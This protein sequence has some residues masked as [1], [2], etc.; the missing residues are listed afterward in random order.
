MSC[1][2]CCSA[3]VAEFIAEMMIHF[4]GVKH[5]TNPGLLLFPEVSI[6][7]DCGFSWFTLPETELASLV[8]AAPTTNGK[9]LADRLPDLRACYWG[10]KRSCSTDRNSWERGDP[11]PLCCGG[12]WGGEWRGSERLCLR[13][14]VLRSFR[15]DRNTEKGRDD[16]IARSQHFSRDLLQGLKMQ[17]PGF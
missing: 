1:A 3:K 10:E 6:C 16:L 4:S 7:L 11:A 9:A 8:R 15:F 14:T 17:M 2:M 12:T 5:L 13:L